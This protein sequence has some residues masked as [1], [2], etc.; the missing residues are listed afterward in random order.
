MKTQNKIYLSK[1]ETEFY[2]KVFISNQKEQLSYQ[3]KHLLKNS[4][5]RLLICNILNKYLFKFSVYLS[6]LKMQMILNQKFK[7]VDRK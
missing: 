3:F 6:R 7:Y 5:N 2:Q 1:N 4:L